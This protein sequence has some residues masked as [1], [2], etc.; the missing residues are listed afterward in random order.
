MKRKWPEFAES[1]RGRDVRENF[2][3][4]QLEAI[5]AV[6]IA[7]NEAEI[8]L[9]IVLGHSLDINAEM[10]FEISTRING[11]DGKVAIIRKSSEIWGDVL[12]E[13]IFDLIENT[14]SSFLECKTYR[15]AVIHAR[16]F[17]TL[18]G[19]GEL[20]RRHGKKEQVLLT[21]EALNGLYD[22]LIILRQELIC[23]AMLFSN[24]RFAPYLAG[25]DRQQPAPKVQEYAARLQE[26]QNDRRSLPPLPAFPK[27]PPTP[28]HMEG[29]RTNT[30]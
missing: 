4:A 25:L 17:D 24:A 28:E 19:I 22:R 26:Y 27:P 12:N 8:I 6:T 29:S 10:W 2:S 11:I 20:M 23:I 3:P 21:A 15:D 9:D 1:H 16:A 14:L 18:G 30:R 7:F 5:G 13:E